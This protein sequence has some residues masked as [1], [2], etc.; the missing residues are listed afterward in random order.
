MSMDLYVW[1]APLVSS[2]DEAIQLLEREDE[3]FEPS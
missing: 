3:A 1:K 2:E